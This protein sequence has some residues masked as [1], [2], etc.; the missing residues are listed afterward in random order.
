MTSKKKVEDEVRALAALR[1]APLDEGAHALLA[2]ALGSRSSAVVAAAAGVLAASPAPQHAPALEQAFERFMQKPLDTDKG[3]LAKTAIARALFAT[4]RDHDALFLRAVRHVQ[5]EPVWGGR[6]DT[7]PEL[8]GVAAAALVQSDYTDVMSVLARLLADP[9]PMARVGAAQAL[10]TTRHSDAALPLLRFKV[11]CGDPDPRVL[12]ACLTSLLSS[13]RERS[14]PFAAELLEATDPALR[15]TAAIALGESRLPAAFAPLRAAAERAALPEE[16][17]PALLGLSL[18]R[19]EEAHA[20]LL[21]RIE[22]DPEPIARLSIEALAVFRHDEAL[23]TA[24]HARAKR[25]PS[26]TALATKLFGA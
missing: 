10:G 9:E 26:L 24:V 21:Q 18:L 8:R 12:A 2:R 5:L 1:D 19:S 6:Q 14:L 13:A 25:S 16:R 11:L 20:Y 22:D 4:E 17:R 3:C 23:R 15:E 7:A